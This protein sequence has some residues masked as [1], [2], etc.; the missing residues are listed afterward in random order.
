MIEQSIE[1]YN[2]WN[3]LIFFLILMFVLGALRHPLV[4]SKA[5]LTIVASLLGIVA[6]TLL[7]MV[8]MLA[9]PFRKVT[10]PQREE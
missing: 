3:T 5:L 9:Y 2:F 7:L 10:D 6:T 4:V 1:A 8:R